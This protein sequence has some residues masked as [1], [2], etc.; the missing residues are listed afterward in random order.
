MLKIS[1]I[2]IAFFLAP[3]HAISA[4]SKDAFVDYSKL[5]Q[6]TNIT[7]LRAGNHDDSGTNTYY[8]MVNAYGLIVSKE[9]RKKEFT[10]RQKHE[11]QLGKIEEFTL[12]SLG[13]WQ[14]EEGFKSDLEFSGEQLRKLVS[15]TM[16]A[17]NILESQVGIL[18]RITMFER[19]KIVPFVGE[20]LEVG[21]TEYFPIP[22]TLPRRPNSKDLKL[23]ITDDKGTLV[24]LEVN[25]E[26]NKG[27][28]RASN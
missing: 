11:M 17:F 28:K 12:P 25:Y 16:K 10:D 15:Q 4:P 9:E 24:E 5:T 20:D 21:F 18:L 6:T 3:V 14:K 26:Q 1:T 13:Y 2:L 22:E 23:E 8:F 27:L 19:Q 7:K